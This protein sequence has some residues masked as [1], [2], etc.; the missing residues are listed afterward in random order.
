MSY[1]TI[2]ENEYFIVVDKSPNILSVPSRLGKADPRPCLGLILEEQLNSP[3]FP[4]HRLDFEVQGLIIY[5]KNPDAQRAANGWFEKKM[6]SKIYS[7][8]TT[9][10]KSGPTE[11]VM[12]EWQTWRCLLLRGKKRAYESPHG[13]SCITQARLLSMADNGIYHWELEPV[14]GRSHQLRYELFR[15]NFP[16]VGDSLYSSPI[17]FSED[18][19][20]LRAYKIDF[21]KTP[22]REKFFLPEKIEIK[23]F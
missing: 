15:H 6:I 1:R 13:K 17:A 7:A 18:G 19:I 11:M 20:A 10:F 3:L 8:L 12:N 23:K 22:D 4:V 9:S 21:S 16:I 2:F 5:A 14:T